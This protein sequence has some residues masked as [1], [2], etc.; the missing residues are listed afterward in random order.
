MNYEIIDFHTHPFF[1]REHNICAY[2]EYCDMNAQ[3]T[4][5]DLNA[6]GITKICGSVISR[7]REKNV[8]FEYVKSL[9]DQALKLKEFYGDFYEVGFHVHP[10]FVKQS[11][12]E[13]ERMHKL[14]VKL[15]GELVP[16]MHGWSDYSL[17]AFS[18]ILEVA[19]HYNMVVSFHTGDEEYHKTQIDEMVRRHRN[20]TLVAAHPC[21]GV[22]FEAHLK[23]MEMSDN[24]Y[25]DLSGGKTYRHGLLK[26]GVT[27]IGAD[28]FLYGSDFPICSASAFL[29]TVKDEFLISE[30]DKQ[31][32]LYKNA[33]KI[34]G[35]K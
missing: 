31:K 9:N 1:E 33:K 10:N 8:T 2:D 18:E 17:P 12:L 13:I 20:L 26:Y 25:L 32:I 30:E 7:V 19:Q 21:D 24:Y 28:R 35:L 5:R 22:P 11:I 4:K 34:L 14:G 15:I 6:L 3:N 23:R 29:A 16:Y 27:R